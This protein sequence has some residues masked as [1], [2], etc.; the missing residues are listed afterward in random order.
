MQWNVLSLILLS[1]ATVVDTLQA[2]QRRRGASGPPFFCVFRNLSHSPTGLF[3]SELFDKGTEPTPMDTPSSVPSLSPSS[4]RSSSPSAAP[5]SSPTVPSVTDCLLNELDDSVALQNGNVVAIN[6]DTK[7]HAAWIS[8]LASNMVCETT[9]VLVS[10]D[11]EEKDNATK[12]LIQPEID[13]IVGGFRNPLND[14]LEWLSGASI[15]P[16][17][18]SW[19]PGQPSGGEQ[20]CL[21]I[22]DAGWNDFDCNLFAKRAIVEYVV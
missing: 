15:N 10:I 9:S 14:Q 4:V 19:A 11:S 1:A 13:Y 8:F 3:D 18:A 20:D 17:D 21:E 7:K 2:Q 16:N 5:S 12:A 6:S 22:S